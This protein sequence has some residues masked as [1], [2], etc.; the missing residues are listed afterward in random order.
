MI[1]KAIVLPPWFADA[2]AF[3]LRSRDQQNIPFEPTRIVV[4]GSTSEVNLI[5]IQ[6]YGMTLLQ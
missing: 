2:V 5:A 3:S 1:Y 6:I 4:V